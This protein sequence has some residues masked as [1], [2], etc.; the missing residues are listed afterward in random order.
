MKGIQAEMSKAVGHEDLASGERWSRMTLPKE[1]VGIE[2]RTL[3]ERD[4]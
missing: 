2:N 1:D 3:K 4:G